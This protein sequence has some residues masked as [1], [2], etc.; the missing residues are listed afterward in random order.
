MSHGLK[1]K[2]GSVPWAVVRTE[3]QPVGQHAS[4]ESV[5]YFGDVC[6]GRTATGANA[7]SVGVFRFAQDLHLASASM[8]PHR[9]T[10]NEI[11]TASA[12]AQCPIGWTSIR[13]RWGYP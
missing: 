9:L 7:P 3:V 13:T 10:I 5:T 6:D 8:P 12:L 11:W 4:G 2:A 1:I